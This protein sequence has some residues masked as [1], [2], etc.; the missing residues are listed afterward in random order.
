MLYTVSA[1]TAEPVEDH[2]TS[3]HKSYRL[4]NSQDL[5]EMFGGVSKMTLHRWQKDPKLNFPKPIFVSRRRF[6]RESELIEFI[7]S[8][9]NQ[10]DAS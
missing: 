10:M 1:Q 3:S 5:R 2:E 9:P 4:I 7:D 8:L 6:W